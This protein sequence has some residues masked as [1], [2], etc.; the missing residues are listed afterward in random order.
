MEM[1][2]QRQN[3]NQRVA[4]WTERISACRSSEQSVRAWCRENGLS[5]KTYYY[6]QRRLFQL[7]AQQQ[8]AFTEIT[9]AVARQRPGLAARVHIGSGEAEIYNGADAA[10]I[11][12]VLQGLR[13]AE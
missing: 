7:A 3:A 4:V 5:E 8:P 6:W 1:E 2:L 13:H 12:A 9:P 10:T 11:E